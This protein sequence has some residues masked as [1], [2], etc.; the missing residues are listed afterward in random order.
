[1]AGSPDLIVVG[2]GLIGCTVALRMALRGATVTVIERGE[3]CR[4]ATWAAGGMLSPF[5]EA[6]DNAAFLDLAVSSLDL[7]PDFVADL[8][9]RSGTDV[10]YRTTGKLQVSLGGHADVL[11]EMAARGHAFDISEL[12]GEDTRALEPALSAAVDGAILIGRDHRVDNR[13]LGDAVRAATGTAGIR[14]L[15]HAMVTSI[16]IDR[17]AGRFRAVRLANGSVMEAETIVIAAGAWS[18]AIAGLPR[19]LPVQPVRGQ[20]LAVAGPVEA[21]LLYHVVHSPGC[22]LIPRQDGRIVVGATAEHVGFEPGPTPAGIAGLTHAAAAVVPGIA[23]LP[24]TETWAG[25][26][27]GTPDDLP[28]LGPD[29][30]IRGVVYATGHYRNGIL[31]AP[32]TARIVE[33]CVIG[34]TPPVRMEAFRPDRFGSA[35]VGP[36][37]RPGPRTGSHMPRNS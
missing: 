10:G 18:G 23:N 20:M 28:I 31:L 19:R 27:P 6:G 3:P 29:P 34:G 1:M 37:W 26:R 30:E 11:R 21:P 9:S 32:I 36:Q 2:G 5:G 22:Y 13:L 7:Y 8:M 4:A 25:F 12:T 15:R 35:D 17:A 16:D 33:A 14:V 24:L